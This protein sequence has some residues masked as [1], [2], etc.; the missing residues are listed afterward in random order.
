M[1]AFHVDI[2]L[3]ED[4]IKIMETLARYDLFQYENNIK[5]DYSNAGGIEM[6]EDGEWVSWEAQMPDGTWTD[7]PEEY[8]SASLI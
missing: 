6:V 1:K 2:E 8:I 4:G 7:D 5:G 3:I